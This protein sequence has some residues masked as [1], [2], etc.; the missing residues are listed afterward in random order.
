MGVQKFG[1][2]VASRS[3]AVGPIPRSVLRLG[4]RWGG[5]PRRFRVES[6]SP[7]GP[8]LVA[9]LLG[10]TNPVCPVNTFLL[11]PAGFTGSVALPSQWLS[12]RSRDRPPAFAGAL[13]RAVAR[14]RRPA[15]QSYNAP[16]L[17]RGSLLA[18]CFWSAF[19]FERREKMVALGTMRQRRTDLLKEGATA[20]LIVPRAHHAERQP[21]V[22]PECGQGRKAAQ[23]AAKSA[24]GG[25]RVD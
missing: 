13:V 19:A 15:L 17:P 21:S 16:G 9:P 23:R 11:N 3:F 25:R 22:I 18:R 6:P 1:Q 20:D 12:W 2:S 7:D 10:A 24:S 8:R 14:Q 5:P 4:R